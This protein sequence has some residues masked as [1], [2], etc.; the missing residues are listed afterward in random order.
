ME[1]INILR[2]I[3]KKTFHTTYTDDGAEIVPFK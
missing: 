1:F 3:S 2:N